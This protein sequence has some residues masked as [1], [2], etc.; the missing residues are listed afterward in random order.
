MLLIL[1]VS[2]NDN[3]LYFWTF[4]N[5]KNNMKTDNRTLTMTKYTWI[6]PYEF[7]ELADI[8]YEYFIWYQIHGI[9]PVLAGTYKVLV[10]IILFDKYF[11]SF[12]IYI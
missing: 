2:E 4:L 6:F 10:H 9:L 12:Y 3:K 11:Q 5:G 1:I 8:R 7:G